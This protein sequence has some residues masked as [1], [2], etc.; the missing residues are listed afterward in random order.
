MKKRKAFI[1]TS[2]LCSSLLISCGSGEGETVPPITEPDDDGDKKPGGTQT[3][4]EPQKEDFTVQTSCDAGSLD[5]DSYVFST[6]KPEEDYFDFDDPILE[7][8]INQTNWSYVTSVYENKVKILSENESVL[9]SS[10]ISY[11]LKTDTNKQSNIII[12]FEFQ[13]DR[14]KVKKGNTKVKIHIEP[15]NG[16]TTA[17]DL[18]LCVPIEI[19][20]F[21]TF[22]PK[23][24]K[25][26]LNVDLT[27]IDEKNIEKGVEL[28]IVD[29]E[30]VYGFKN[31]ESQRFELN[32]VSTVIEFDL[33]IGNKVSFTAGY[34]DENNKR[35]R[36]TLKLDS[37]S[38]F[39]ENGEFYIFK[40]KPT[41]SLKATLA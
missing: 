22:G 41:E 15:S 9:P 32:T 33:P 28:F 16:V 31:N 4:E 26:S 11:R 36:K 37:D 38:S 2:L 21:G 12:G 39:E 13:I 40:S 24:E 30:H 29:E 25:V 23:V 27:G 7:V 8:A 3:P 35:E 5:K 18:N 1:I 20:E 17:S 14:T 10:A 34:N 6:V 19:K